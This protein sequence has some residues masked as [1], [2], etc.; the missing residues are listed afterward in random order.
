MAAKPI[1]PHGCGCSSEDG[2]RR[3][4]SRPFSASR[5]QSGFPV[6]TMSQAI[7]PPGMAGYRWFLSFTSSSPTR[8]TS[9]VNASDASPPQHL[10]TTVRTTLSLSHLFARQT[11]P[12]RPHSL[13]RYRYVSTKVGLLGSG[14]L[15][16]GSCA[17]RSAP[18]LSAPTV[19][20]KMELLET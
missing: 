13:W 7:H 8:R 19:T 2:L 5:H 11:P 10:R 1:G 17:R 14:A 6:L 15:S 18:P 16:R 9:A 20:C 12:S 3:N 4:S